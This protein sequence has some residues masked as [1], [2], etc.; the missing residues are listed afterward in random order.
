MVVHLVLA[1]VIWLPI[2]F[3]AI[4]R[5]YDCRPE[6]LAGIT[7]PFAGH[8]IPSNVTLV[9]R[10]RWFQLSKLIDVYDAADN[11]HLG[12][13]YDMQLLFFLRFGFSD[14]EDR[15][16][17]EAKFASFWSRF[18]WNLEYHVQR[19]DEQAWDAQRP[20]MGTY[21]IR[22]DFWAKSWL[23]FTNCRREFDI[24]R[25]AESSSFGR[26][27]APARGIF[28]SHLTNVLLKLRHAWFL[29]LLSASGEPIAEA[30]QHFF[31]G[32]RLGVSALSRWTLRIHE[33]QARRAGLPNWVIGFMAA[34]D[35][36]EEGDE[37]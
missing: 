27:A 36:I 6:A 15:I 37:K 29:H 12:Y 17:F 10:R 28:D 19:C 16:W 18:K 4:G 3:V 14:A 7:P 1:L 22:E 13:F 23:C 20:T 25:L 31:R 9:E 5:N 32:G 26:A 8:L 35:D 11:S 21:E 30:E 33:A 34:L 24:R 2:L